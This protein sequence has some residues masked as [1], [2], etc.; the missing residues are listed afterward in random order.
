VTTQLGIQGH[1]GGG[2]R[3]VVEWI[4]AGAIGEVREVLAWCDLSYY[5]AGHASWSPEMLQRPK[6]G[7]QVPDTLDW[8]LWIG[9]ASMRPF[10][11]VYHP[12]SWRAWWDFGTG[13]MCDRGAHTLDPVA[14]ALDLGDPVSVGARSSL[15]LNDDTHPLAAIVTYTFPRGGGKDPLKLTWYEGL[16]PPRPP[17]LKQGQKLGAQ[18]GGA[19][20]RGTEASLT[21]GVYGEDPRILPLDRMGERLE[22]RKEQTLPRIRTTH[23]MQWVQ[24]CKEGKQATADFGYGG[25]LCELCTLGNV[26]KRVN[27]SFDWDAEAMKATDLPDANRYVK[28]DFRDGWSL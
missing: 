27:G 26:A 14:W 12:R 9:P 8:D 7:M 13:M 19:L 1:S 23:Q 18:Q 15:G 22:G 28:P 25:H 21:C 5:P 17:E 24:A 4:R 11:R 3:R 10:H 20:F 6:K 2:A 16:R